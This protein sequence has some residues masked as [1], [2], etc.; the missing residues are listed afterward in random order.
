MSGA[1]DLT[2]YPIDEDSLLGRPG[3]YDREPRFTAGAWRFTAV[4]LGGI[5]AL[6]AET[7]TALSATARADPLARAAFGHALV[8]TRTAGLWVREAAIRAARRMPMPR[9]LRG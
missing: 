1:Y 2:G 6:L 4:Q 9:R 5:E 3:D 7:R 8:A